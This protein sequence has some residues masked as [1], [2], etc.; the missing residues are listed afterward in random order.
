MQLSFTGLSAKV[1][2]SFASV[3]NIA[4]KRLDIYARFF[5]FL[6]F[7]LSQFFF[8]VCPSGFSRE[9]TDNARD[10][11]RKKRNPICLLNHV[12]ADV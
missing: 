6:L 9:R 3:V 5:Y 1:R 11:K 7:S 4:A 10:Q 2:F 12:Y 8:C